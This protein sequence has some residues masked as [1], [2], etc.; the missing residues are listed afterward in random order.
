MK[1]E[2]FLVAEGSQEFEPLAHTM[3]DAAAIT[4][5]SRAK[6]YKILNEGG[7]T[8]KKIGRRTIILRGV[9]IEFLHALPDYE[10]ER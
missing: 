3:E 4:G 9:L 1:H 6:L 7:L 8:G 10:A 2:T 5:I